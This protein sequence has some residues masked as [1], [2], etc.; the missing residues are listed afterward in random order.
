MSI[1][2]KL[3]FNAVTLPYLEGLF[4]SPELTPGKKLEPLTPAQ[5]QQ[6]RAAKTL[7]DLPT[8]TTYQGET[9]PDKR[10][11]GLRLTQAAAALGLGKSFSLDAQASG[12]GVETQIQSLRRD[13]LDHYQAL[14]KATPGKTLAEWTPAEVALA[15]AKGV[16]PSEISQALTVEYLTMLTEGKVQE[17]QSY[18]AR[19]PAELITATGALERD[20]LRVFAERLSSRGPLR[21]PKDL[22]VLDLLILA[23]AMAPERKPRILERALLEAM[24]NADGPAIALLRPLVD[25]DSISL[26]GLAHAYVEGTETLLSR[27]LETRSDAD[28]EKVGERS[29]LPD[30]SHSYKFMSAFSALVKEG[31]FTDAHR[32]DQAWAQTF[33]QDDSA[34]A[35]RTQHRQHALNEVLRSGLNA[36]L[37]RWTKA[38]SADDPLGMSQ[39]AL[40]L[41]KFA[42][43]MLDSLYSGQPEI[44]TRLATAIGY[45]PRLADATPEQRLAEVQAFSDSIPWTSYL[46][47]S[48]PIL[49]PHGSKDLAPTLRDPASSLGYTTP[50]LSALTREILR[51]APVELRSADRELSAILKEIVT[52]AK[53]DPSNEDLKTLKKASR[54]DLRAA[55]LELRSLVKPS[56]FLKLPTV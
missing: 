16:K 10:T 55:L 25:T 37:E 53:K 12:Y 11:L 56:V 24:S 46:P 48:K 28:L 13:I 19:F 4:Y 50:E 18:R 36:V 41:R 30:S 23:G 7:A 42:L 14:T 15:T 31:S 51:R 35:T 22:D 33:D 32:L 26:E 38:A 29:K 20:A 49:L 43:P 6:A 3:P 27:F 47:A 21:T 52:A 44:L 45:H 39:A 40:E 34:R 8:T 2:T 5:V 54:L 9:V 17:A 1:D